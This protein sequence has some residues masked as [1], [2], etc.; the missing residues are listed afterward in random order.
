MIELLNNF[1]VSDWLCIIAMMLFIAGGFC[2]PETY[3][4]EWDLLKLSKDSYMIGFLLFSF[5]LVGMR[6]FKGI[7]LTVIYCELIFM[8]SVY[9]LELN[10]LA[11]AITATIAVAILTTAFV[12]NKFGGVELT[13]GSRNDLFKMVVDTDKFLNNPLYKEGLAVSN[14]NEITVYLRTHKIDLQ[15]HEVERCIEILDGYLPR[16]SKHDMRMIFEIEDTLE[17]S[18]K[19]KHP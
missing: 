14:V 19:K 12:V 3:E 13:E 8:W 1:K 7:L 18:L 17:A 4:Y 16:A 11:P 6:E 9:S 5:F 15:K 10:I 2:F